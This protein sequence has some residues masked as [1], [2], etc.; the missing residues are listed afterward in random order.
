MNAGTRIIGRRAFGSI[1]SDTETREA[2]LAWPELS[3]GK[4]VGPA[5]RRSLPDKMVG[6]NQLDPS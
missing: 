6:L 1:T 2:C 4:Q 5:S 3:G